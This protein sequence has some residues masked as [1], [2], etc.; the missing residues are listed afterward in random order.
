MCSASSP[1]TWIG[2]STH[3]SHSSAH[4][5]RPAFALGAFAWHQ[6]AT[7]QE[8]LDNEYYFSTLG[9]LATCL[10]WHKLRVPEFKPRVRQ[11]MAKFLEATCPMDEIYKLNPRAP[12]CPMTCQVCPGPAGCKCFQQI[13]CVPANHYELVEY[14]VALEKKAWCPTCRAQLKYC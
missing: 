12:Q 6:K 9:L 3:A 5:A 13:A 14:L 8:E 7:V 4:G 2:S 11:V 1:S 10:A